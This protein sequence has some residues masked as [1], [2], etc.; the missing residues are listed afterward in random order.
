MGAREAI[1][2]Q[3]SPLLDAKSA[4]LRSQGAC[5]PHPE[6]V[7]QALFCT[8]DFFDPRDLVQVRYE[9]VRRVVVNGVTP[10]QAAREFGCSRTTWYAARAAF[11]AD[12]LFGLLPRKPGPHGAHKVTPAV[13]SY[14]TEACRHDATL[15]PAVLASEVIRRFGRSIHP[16]TIRRAL[17]LVKNTA[18]A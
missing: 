2:T 15:T 11:L 7:T 10:T 6:R 16:R 17:A 5:H 4:L 18:R 9:M 13:L 14:L 3:G 1:M 8:H 12:G